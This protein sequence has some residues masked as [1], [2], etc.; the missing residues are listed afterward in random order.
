MRFSG[1]KTFVL[2]IYYFVRYAHILLDSEIYRSI[3]CKCP[4]KYNNIVSFVPLS[5]IDE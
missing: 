4:L 3:L 1:L 5:E 2:I